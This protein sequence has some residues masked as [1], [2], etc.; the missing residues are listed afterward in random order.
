MKIKRLNPNQDSITDLRNKINELVDL[1]NASHITIESN[2]V[3]LNTIE[4]LLSTTESITCDTLTPKSNEFVTLAKVH[5]VA[6]DNN[7]AEPKG[8]Y[9]DI[10]CPNCGERYFEV[11]PSEC[12]M[13]YCPPIYKDGKNINPDTNTCTTWFTCVN[14][15]HSWKE[16]K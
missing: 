7:I 8:L 14:C 2:T 9:D 12:T 6:Y 15:G 1:V 10:K 5:N 3:D 11:G 13:L 16:T 4:C